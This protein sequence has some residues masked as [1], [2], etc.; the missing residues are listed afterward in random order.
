MLRYVKESKE[1]KERGIGNMKVMVNSD[2]P[3][4]VRLLMR[5][6][7]VFKLCCNQMLAKDT[8]FSALPNT[9]SALSW[10]GQDFSEN[11]LQVEMLA[12]RFKTA[13]LCKQFHDAILSAQAQMTDGSRE[14]VDRTNANVNI[15][16]KDKTASTGASK[17]S[18]VQTKP[19]FTFG[20]ST[21]TNKSDR[22][23]E[24]NAKGFGN[25]FKPKAGS[26]SCK[27]CYTQNNADTLHCICC[28]EP[29]D[30]SIPKK[31]KQN[32]IPM[33]KGKAKQI[34]FH[35]IS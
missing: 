19:P 1:W 31:E 18:E 20:G 8:K 25:Q 35:L 11:E 15:A 33:A 16:S 14:N 12:I 26:W 4:K 6:E 13:E 3:N 29:K 10:F 32:F 9:K 21:S 30:D 22:G 7:Q 27:A 5:R 2:D 17:K 28:E 24:S 23:S 34:I